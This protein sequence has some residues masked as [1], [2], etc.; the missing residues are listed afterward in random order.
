LTGNVEATQARRFSLRI[1]W[2]ICIMSGLVAAFAVLLGGAPKQPCWHADDAR[3]RRNDEGQ[4]R[5]DHHDGQ[6]GRNQKERHGDN[7][8]QHGRKQKEWHGENGC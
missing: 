3:R 7:G 6:H 5:H 4:N 2:R 8:C 1:V